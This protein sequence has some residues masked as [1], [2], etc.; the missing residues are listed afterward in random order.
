MVELIQIS[1]LHYGSEFKE[2]YIEN[3]INYINDCRP[4]AVICTGDIAHKGRLEQFQGIV[5]YL[6]RIKP[7]LLI[8]PGNHDA[9]NN[10]LLFFE[11]L[12]GPRR[13]TMLIE[14]KDTILVGLSSVMDDIKDGEIGDEQLLWLAQQ[15]ENPK[16]P[17]LENRVIALHHH[18]IPL[19]L[20]G[21]KWT[22]VRDAG[23]IL[24]FTQ[25]YNIDLVLSGHRHVPHAWV[26]GPTTFLYC[27]TS[28]TEKVRADEPPSFN[29][30]Y[31][32]K[33]D[34]EVF[35]VSSI[36]LEKNVLLTRKDGKTEFIR[37]RKAR[38]EHLLKTNYL[39]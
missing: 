37:P 11:K 24:E 1:D 5:A 2:E 18:L 13:R 14:E 10:G 19:P 31:L 21:K 28:S 29:H 17:L 35:M 26:I 27:G 6:K 3:I 20:A 38:I 34:L 32:D 39:D 30:I 9:K 25:I 8:V 36:D 15:F 12:L 7:K 4:D 33:G 16:K 22:T 23:E